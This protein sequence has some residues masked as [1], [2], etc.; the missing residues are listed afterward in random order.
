MWKRNKH[1]CLTKFGKVYAYERD[2]RTRD[3]L[4]SC[5]KKNKKVSILKKFNNSIK[6]DYILLADVLEHIKDDDLALKKLKKLLKSGGQI[7]I[8]VPAYNFLFSKKDE[9]LKHFRRY[10]YGKIKNLVAKNFKIL[11]ITFF[12]SLLFLPIALITLIL[13]ILRAD[14]IDNVENTPNKFLNCLLYSIFKSE[15]IFLKYVDFPFGVS[16]I[17]I[18]E[19]KNH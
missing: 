3:Y 11:R 9:A 8:T 13:K 2:K 16:I 6:Y 10:D 7:L 18:G 1:N 17:I 19:K 12:N 4:I 14:Y 15:L 5:Y